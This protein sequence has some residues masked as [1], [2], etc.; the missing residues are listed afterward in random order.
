MK[1]VQTT[2]V[3]VLL[4]IS[5]LCVASCEKTGINEG[6]M[7]VTTQSVA[8]SGPGG[9][10]WGLHN[11]LVFENGDYD[12]I[13]VP[14]DCFDEIVIIVTD[15]SFG[16][17]GPKGGSTFG[18]KTT[19]LKTIEMYATDYPE[20]LANLKSGRFSIRELPTTNSSKKLFGVYD[21]NDENYIIYTFQFAVK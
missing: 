19:I 13:P 12:C 11:K 2:L 1:K 10:G 14:V 20:L 5:M 17:D 8:K 9:D 18:D 6:N 21:S 7:P 3:S 16:D 15:T 4:A